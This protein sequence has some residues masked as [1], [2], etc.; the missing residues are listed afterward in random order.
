MPP[1]ALHGEAEGSCCPASRNP[2]LSAALPAAAARIAAVARSALAGPTATG[3]RLLLPLLGG[4]GG[5]GLERRPARATGRLVFDLTHGPISFLQGR[6]TEPDGLTGIRSCGGP[7]P[8]LL[9]KEDSARRRRLADD[10]ILPIQEGLDGVLGVSGV[11]AAE[12]PPVAQDPGLVDDERG[13]RHA[14]AEEIRRLALQGW[15]SST[16]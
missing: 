2:G 15:G 12:L 3:A 14:D 11:G 1:D 4:R 10:D 7:G 16:A 8:G 5:R 13:G 6:R 9:A